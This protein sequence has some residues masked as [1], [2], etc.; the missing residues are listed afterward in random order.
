MMN[1]RKITL[2]FAPA[3]GKSIGGA[4]ENK[5]QPLGTP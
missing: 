3:C 4:V 2:T 5:H 1:I